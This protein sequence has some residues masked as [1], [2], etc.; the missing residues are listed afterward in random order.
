VLQAALV[1]EL[2][3]MVASAKEAAS[4]AQDAIEAGA[5]RRILERIAAFGR[6]EAASG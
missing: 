2:M 3:G 1:L 5:G 4:M 6:G